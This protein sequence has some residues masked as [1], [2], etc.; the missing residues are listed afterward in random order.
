VVNDR[1]HAA[2]TRLVRHMAPAAGTFPGASLRLELQPD[3]SWSQ[4]VK[5]T[6]KAAA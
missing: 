6:P 2:A 1:V 5:L 4:S 3:G